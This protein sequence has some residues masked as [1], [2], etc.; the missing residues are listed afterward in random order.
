MD[1]IESRTFAA[2]L[3]DLLRNEQ[4]AMADFLVAL[5]EFDRQR[6]WITLGYSGLFPFLHQKLELSKSASFFRK[7]AAE[8]IQSYPE[9]V[10]PLR[11]GRLC[12]S[13]M[14]SVAKVLTPANRDEVLPRFFHRS[15]LEA[16][17]IV[18]EL[19]PVQLPPTRTVV[20]VTAVPT[21]PPAPAQISVTGGARGSD[22][23]P[24][25]VDESTKAHAEPL[26][27]QPSP[28]LRV[29]P[30]TPNVTRI[31]VSV[32]PAFVTKLED[33]RL[34]LSH[35]MPGAD[36]EAILSAGL[37]LLLAR[38]AKNKA[39][40]EKPRSTLADAEDAPDSDHV[41]AAVEREVRKRDDGRCQWP[42]DSG[43]VCGSRLRVEIDHIIPKAHGGRPVIGNLRLLCAH[44]NKLAARQK[45]GH[46]LM[47]RYCRDPR[48]PLFSGIPG[49]TRG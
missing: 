27:L 8:L 16:K 33:A 40:V 20:T 30:L 14:A 35:S 1:T 15:A 18:A 19:A 37:D 25:G 41:P 6:G 13:T 28:S 45:L 43:G 9:I 26:I 29:E 48:L 12:L 23:E 34:A 21:L 3:A 11:D 32:S 44:H 46:G 47:N 31:H 22:G 2:R 38:D 5:A 7:T 42:V 39:L 49:D 17:A 24:R 10:E 4:L 36:A